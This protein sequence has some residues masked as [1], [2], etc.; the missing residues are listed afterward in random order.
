MVEG[1]NTFEKNTESSISHNEGTFNS[2]S[3]KNFGDRVEFSG[4]CPGCRARISGVEKRGKTIK[5]PECSAISE[6]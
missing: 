2:K 1:E 6:V 3:K 5:C 4:S